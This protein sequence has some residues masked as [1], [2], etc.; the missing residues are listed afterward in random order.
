MINMTK[1]ITEK[2]VTEGE[3]EVTDELLEKWAEPW[4]R[5]EVP[6]VAAGFVASPGRPCT[7]STLT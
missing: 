4:E 5:G 3:V 2:F 6:G 1:N 7:T